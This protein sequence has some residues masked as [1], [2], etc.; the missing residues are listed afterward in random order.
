MGARVIAACSTQEKVDLAIQAR[1][2]PA[3]SMAAA[4]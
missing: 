1:R 4:L 3:W 2:D